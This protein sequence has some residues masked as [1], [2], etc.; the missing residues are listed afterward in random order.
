M[1]PPVDITALQAYV[2]GSP[3]LREAVG[4]EKG[5]HLVLR[6][7]AQGEYNVNFAFEAAGRPLLLRVNTGS[8]LDLADQIDYEMGALELLVPSGRTPRPYFV[9]GSRSRVPWGVGVEELLPGGPLDYGRDLETAA[10]V[11]ADIHGVPVAEDTPLV[12]PEHPLADIVAECG[13]MISVY[14]AWGRAD[15]AVLSRVRTMARVADRLADDDLARPAP[16][17]RSIVNTE[18]NSGNFLVGEGFAYLVDWEKPVAGEPAQDLAHFLAPTTTFWKT[19]V[20]LTPA[21]RDRFVVAYLERSRGRVAAGD[22]DG[23]LGDY[24]TVTCLR[25]VTW[26]AMAKVSYASGTRAVVNADT[27]AKIDDYLA[28]AFLDALIEDWYR[29]YL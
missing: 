13:R 22:L 18:V 25:G 28:P 12:R 2:D 29:P 23:R 9:D 1:T 15:P 8:Q 5:E 19:D 7:F 21:D 26:C 10:A 6:P 11:L 20:V 16:K 27:A 24:L 14:E 4:A 17:H 3:R